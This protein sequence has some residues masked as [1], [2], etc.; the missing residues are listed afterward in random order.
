MEAVLNFD[1]GAAFEPEPNTDLPRV[2]PERMMFISSEGVEI[3][4]T[5]ARIN[6]VVYAQIANHGK[7]QMPKIEVKIPGS[8]HTRMEDNPT[9]PEYLK[10]LDEWREYSSIQ[11]GKYLFGIGVK[12][13]APDD[14][15]ADNIE[16]VPDATQKDLKYMWIASL[17]PDSND[18]QALI[19]AILGF[20]VPTE[21]GVESAAN[22]SESK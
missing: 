18:V 11:I 17:V 6:F 4:L 14:W 12:G 7:P 21:K 9:N 2:D 15:I 3:P 1:E 19:E 13:Q 10:R 5:G 16:F 22:F 20:S 8:K